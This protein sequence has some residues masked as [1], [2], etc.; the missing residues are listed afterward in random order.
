M[1]VLCYIL[2]AI[3]AIIIVFCT[4][5]VVMVGIQESSP[6]ETFVRKINDSSD[7]LNKS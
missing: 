7:K 4:W 1:E 3:L 2:I 6:A 5:V